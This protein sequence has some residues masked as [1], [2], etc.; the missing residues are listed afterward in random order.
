MHCVGN[1]T[2]LAIKLGLGRPTCGGL[3]GVRAPRAHHLAIRA[4]GSREACGKVTGWLRFGL[5]KVNTTVSK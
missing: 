2:R 4:R 1:G 3:R 5:V